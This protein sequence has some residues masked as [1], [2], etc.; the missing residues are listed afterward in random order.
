[1]APR[2]GRVVEPNITAF[3]TTD[4]SVGIHRNPRSAVLTDERDQRQMLTRPRGNRGRVVARERARDLVPR[5][6]AGAT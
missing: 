5:N 2:N 4:D 3:A 6:V 1:M